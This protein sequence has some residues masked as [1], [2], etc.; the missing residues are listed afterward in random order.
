MINKFDYTFGV[1]LFIL[2]WDLRAYYKNVLQGNLTRKQ[3]EWVNNMRYPQLY[4]FT[5]LVS[6]VAGIVFLIFYMFF[7]FGYT[8]FYPLGVVLVIHFFKDFIRNIQKKESSIY[9][10]GRNENYIYII[11]IMFILWIIFH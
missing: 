10:D 5:N 1:V 6:I 4:K 9:K 11:G 3:Q 2:V 8:Y 7:N